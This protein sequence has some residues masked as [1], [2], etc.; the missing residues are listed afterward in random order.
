M[1]AFVVHG[2]IA[3]FA[4]SLSSLRIMIFYLDGWVVHNA[5]N[6]PICLLF[7]FPQSYMQRQTIKWIG[8][9]V[10][11]LAMAE[12]IRL[13]TANC[14]EWILRESLNVDR[15]SV[16]TTERWKTANSLA[17]SGVVVASN[18]AWKTNTHVGRSR[19]FAK[20]C[21]SNKSV[22]SANA[23]HSKNFS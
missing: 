7:R 3:E 13:P 19:Q 1:F 23:I 8:I 21:F 17:V 22:T 9:A 4:S 20:K 5:N 14:S 6:L 11:R 12:E 15:S 10:H 18:F 2:K 16:E